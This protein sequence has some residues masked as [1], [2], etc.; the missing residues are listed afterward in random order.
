MTVVT[1]HLVNACQECTS[2]SHHALSAR[3][4]GAAAA[5]AGSSEAVT[6]KQG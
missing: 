6:Q 2:L 3:I 1:T 4:P 5:A